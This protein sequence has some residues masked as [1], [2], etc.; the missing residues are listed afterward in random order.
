MVGAA[1]ESRGGV[2]G[3]CEC[4]GQEADHADED[5]EIELHGDG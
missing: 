2:D 1:A 3:S 4:R 5:V